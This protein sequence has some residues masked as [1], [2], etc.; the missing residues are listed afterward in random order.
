MHSQS[1]MLAKRIKEDIQEVDK[2]LL[3]EEYDMALLKIELLEK[4]SVYISIDTNRLS[5]NLAKAKAYLGKGESEKSINILL[6]GLDELNT[7]KESVLRGQY[8]SFLGKIF[9]TTNDFNKAIKYYTI[10]LK[11]GLIRNDTV[12]ILDSYFS[13]GRSYHLLE[14]LDSA[15]HYYNQVVQYPINTKTES[16]IA[17][18]Y[19][20]LV[21]ITR[22]GED[23]QLAEEYAHKIIE[24]KQ[25]F[26]DTIGISLG[27]LQLGSI[28]YQKEEFNKAKINYLKAY[29]LVEFI[30]S[31]RAKLI[32]ENLLNNLAYVN[33]VLKDFEKA[34]IYLGEANDLRDSI[35]E[36]KN[37]QNFS[38]IEAKYNVAEA[39]RIAE[40]EKSKRLRTNYFFY[41]LAIAF[42][43][44]L[45]FG[46]IF[47]NNYRLKQRNKL[48]QVENEMNT[49][50][51]NA[52]IDAKEKERKTIAEILHDSVS[53]LLSSANLHLQ[54]SK[55]QLKKSSPK[56]ISKAQTILNEASIK[57]RDLSH[58]LI[59]SVLLKFGLAF[60]VH[61]M[62]Q[63]YSNSEIS[64]FSDDNG[65][66]R[67]DQDFE[68]KIHNIIEELIN[69]ILKH[70]KAS[71]ATIMLTHR[72][73]DKL[74]IRINDDGIGFDVGSARKKD[75]LGL[76]H[77]S[78]RVKIMKGVFNIESSKGE[79]TSI[80]I[81][82]PIK[83]KE[84]EAA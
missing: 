5:L 51:I 61:D 82:V 9:R 6:S 34:Y 43:A 22:N 16:F 78:A 80:F 53:A 49:K 14:V 26:K 68:I 39:G 36:A 30:H 32:K 29:E 15:D 65:I 57:I 63:K 66:K 48:E 79:G 84:E 70:S 1:E 69:N 52:T 38:E 77:I 59:S 81:L 55:A 41:S 76:S 19:N 64:L 31:S 71:N 25:Q 40:E 20:N 18:A 3:N 54:A 67:Y 72:E 35:A 45:V 47:Y 21:V 33:G 12:D 27:I 58:N 56:E 42:M 10:L 37:S 17:E 73:D 83:L 24:I 13:I 74:T 44:F 62:C 8:A 46:Y 4:Y 23:F 28:H 7:Q 2:R 50:I 75:G 11:N 60:A